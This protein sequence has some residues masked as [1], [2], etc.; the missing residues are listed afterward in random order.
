VIRHKDGAH[1]IVANLPGPDE[2]ILKAF[3]KGIS[4]NVLLECKSWTDLD[5]YILVEALL[6]NAL[7]RDPVDLTTPR[8]VRVRFSAKELG[9]GKDYGVELFSDSMSPAIAPATYVE[10]ARGIL[11]GV[12]RDKLHEGSNRGVKLGLETYMLTFGRELCREDRNSTLCDTK[13]DQVALEKELRYVRERI[14]PMLVMSLNVRTLPEPRFETLGKPGS[15][16]LQH[17]RSLERPLAVTA[18]HVA[19]ACNVP[20]V[21]VILPIVDLSGEEGYS[22]YIEGLRAVHP[23][24]RLWT[25]KEARG[26][27]SK[28]G[29]TMQY[30][31]RELRKCCRCVQPLEECEHYKRVQVKGLDNK[32]GMSL[33]VLKH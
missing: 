11:D 4:L 32:W 19:L 3:K 12:V 9:S 8:L 15:K 30:F 22:K 33:Q 31:R 17:K 2:R 20:G 25:R 21:G 1:Q 28:L 18:I 6:S 14:E 27:P 13:W 10:A 5:F 16:Y 23:T 24:V 7:G 29:E 26:P